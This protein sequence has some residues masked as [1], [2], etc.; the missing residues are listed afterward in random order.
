MEIEHLRKYEGG[1]S[2]LDF[3]NAHVYGKCVDVHDGDTITLAI[4]L[5]KIYLFKVRMYGYNSAEVRTT[6]PEE[7]KQGLAARD[8]LRSMILGKIVEAHGLGL[9]KYGR[10]LMNIY[11]L[12]DKFVLMEPP[13]NKIMIERGYGKPYFGEGEKHW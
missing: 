3:K 11:Q 10:L 1:A 8:F 12:D 6:N 13:L 2:F 4:Q 7:K 9:D 5:D